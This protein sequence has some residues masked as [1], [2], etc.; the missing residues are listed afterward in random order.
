MVLYLLPECVNQFAPVVGND[1]LKV[2]DLLLIDKGGE[3][4]AVC[5]KQFLEEGYLAFPEHGGGKPFKT[6][7]MEICNAGLQK[8]GSRGV[9]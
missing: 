1:A 8:W 9:E 2:V 4:G 6:L 3:I 7:I 5:I